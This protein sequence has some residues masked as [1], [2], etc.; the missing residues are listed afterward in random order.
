LWNGRTKKSI[1][2]CLRSRPALPFTAEAKCSGI[3]LYPSH[4]GGTF[5]H[6]LEFTNIV[7]IGIVLEDED[8]F[9]G[10]ADVRERVFS[11]VDAEKVLSES[12]DVRAAFA[13]RGNRNAN[14]VETVIEIFAKDF[15][16]TQVSRSR[17]VAAMVPI[18]DIIVVEDPA[19]MHAG[20][21]SGLFVCATVA[22]RDATRSK[23]EERKREQFCTPETGG[24]NALSRRWHAQDKTVGC[25]EVDTV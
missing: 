8:G 22:A 6:V 18:A 11:A 3:R 24:Q 1:S 23:A 21:D 16:R 20:R 5:D 10:K 13:E 15:S 25:A 12:N 7:W 9:I 17:L 2:T 19:E 14:D 4:Q